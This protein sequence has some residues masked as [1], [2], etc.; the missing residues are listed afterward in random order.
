[1]SLTVVYNLSFAFLTILALALFIISI[2][3]YKRSKKI[4]LLMV[5]F[6][7]LLFFVKGLWLTYSLFYIPRDSWDPFLVPVAVLDCLI[8]V[9]LY[10]SI[11]KR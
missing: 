9:L 2:L 1:M 6:A 4:K 5:S 7:F 11:L 3:A 8:L 10:I